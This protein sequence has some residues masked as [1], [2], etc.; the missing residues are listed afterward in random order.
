MTRDKRGITVT[1]QQSWRGF[2][3]EETAYEIRWLTEPGWLALQTGLPTLCMVATE[4]GGQCELRARPDRPVEGEYFGSDALTFAAPGSSVAIYAAE[5]RQARLCCFALHTSDADYLSPEEIAAI[6]L[7]RS[8]YMF[9]NDR[10]RTCAA[11]LDNDRTRAG[12]SNTY[13]LSLS[14]ALFAAVLDVIQG[15]HEREQPK[16]AALSGQRWNAVTRYLRDHLSES[17]SVAS[18][19]AIA[20]MPPDQFSPAFRAAT[21][22]SLRQ[23]Q[24]DH[25]VRAAQ[26]LLVDNPHE[27]LAEVAALCAFQDQSHFS[28]AFLK[29]V[30]QTPTAWLHSRT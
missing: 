25:R 6:G 18:L 5:M 16:P 23:W 17:I 27:N 3:V 1:H 7:L 24:M 14:R 12:A 15:M 9:R 30:G 2:G 11:L 10:I 8:R 29:V 26:R 19:A 22:M 13:V 4:V 21:G 20:R 28:R